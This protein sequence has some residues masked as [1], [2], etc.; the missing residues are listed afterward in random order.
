MYIFSST[1][2]TIGEKTFSNTK[3]TFYIPYGSKAVYKTSTYWNQF[4]NYVEFNQPYNPSH[5][6]VTLYITDIVGDI[7]RWEYSRDNGATWKNIECKEYCYTE[8]N[9]ECGK[10]LYRAL[11]ADGTYSNIVTTN[12]ID[13]VPKTITTT[14]ANETKTVDETVTFTL[15]V[16]DDGYTYQWMHNDIAIEGATTNSYSIPSIK[17]DNAGKYYCVV[18]NPVGS[19]NSTA[20]ELI[21]NKCPQVIT[22]PDFDIKTYGDEPFSLPKTTDKGLIINYQSIN[23]NIA[24]IDGN[25]VTIKGVGETNIIATQTGNNDYLEAS[26]VSRKLTVKKISQT[27]TFDELSAKTYEDIPFALPAT[28]DK[29]LT[30]AYQSSNTSV[31]T[32]EGNNVTIVGAGTTEIIATQA[33]DEYHYA[34]A[35]VSRVLTVNRKQQNITFNAFGTVVY[36]DTPI[37]LNQFTNKNLEITYTSSDK[38]V[39]TVSGNKITIVKPGITV[40]KAIQGGTNNYLP[41]QSIERTLIVNKASQKIE[42]YELKAKYYGDE[43]FALPDTTDKGLIINYTSDNTSVAT[44]NGNVVSIK[45]AG[46][47]NITATQDGNDYYSAATSVTL[48]LTVSKA[49]QAITFNELPIMT[50]GDAPLELNATTNSSDVVIYNSSD[51]TVATISDNI[52]TIVGAGKC[53]ITASC[54]GDSNY[55]G[56]TSIQRELVVNRAKQTISIAEISDKMYGDKPF[57]IKAELSSNEPVNFV[58]SNASILSIRDSIATIR[59]A[60]K[61][62]ITATQDE[63]RNYEG[64]TVQLEVVVGKAELFVSVEDTIRVYG[65]ENPE[66]EVLFNGFVNGDTKEE[67]DYIP[68]ATCVANNM[69]NTGEY[70]I[71]I[72]KVTDKNYSLV[73]RNGILKVKKAPITVK[74][75]NATKVYGDKNPSFTIEYT[76]FKNNQ[77]QREFTSQAT[78][79]TE[80]K[81]MSPAGE[82]A[83]IAEGAKAT[84]YEF[85]Y[86]DAVLSIEKAPLTLTLKD[87]ERT[88]GEVNEYKIQYTGF[89]G[90]DKKES[91]D[92]LPKVISEVDEKTSAGSYNMT[93]QGGSDDNYSYI[94]AY[95]TNN[96]HAVVKINK[97]RL[98]IIADDKCIDYSDS[99]PLFTF[100]YEGFVNDDTVE[101][102][103]EQPQIECDATN[104]SLP[105]TYEIILFGGHDKNY[106]Y[107]FEN[108]TLTIVAPS[109]IG[110]VTNENALIQIYTLRGVLV[111]EGTNVPQTLSS[112]TYILRRGN[113]VQKT[114][115]K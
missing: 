71:V 61:V 44:I 112:G 102:L 15:G 68:I 88:Y 86:I 103:E 14:P 25:I 114:Y 9:P 76:G 113:V 58:S 100:S 51:E 12:Y 28:T 95:E 19:T 99:L 43:D 97:A 32:I 63:T 57:V 108:A 16:K 101:S 37:E 4:A 52:L 92:E 73:C 53:I 66:F 77:N 54:N 107:I 72:G 21:V 38:G 20:V 109:R 10:V 105:G 93:L 82:Y 59:G 85:E 74:P 91:L 64:A 75:V 42:W 104:E 3:I 83:I 26:Y 23:T 39:A 11:K 50:Y 17:S 47:A 7:A 6:P 34:A 79:T 31:A 89:K 5:Q 27:I 96:D 48:T 65:D 36:G 62:V 30:I 1:P 40:I 110:K 60:G 8:Q 67:L 56:A 49:S 80:A 46:T 55:F 87:I 22:L 106:E 29:G 24:T 18:S 84:N 111:Y 90:S 2:P 94:Y 98:K 115:I 81:T 41:A 45:G 13:Q 70:N 69:S 78:A 35:P 33:G